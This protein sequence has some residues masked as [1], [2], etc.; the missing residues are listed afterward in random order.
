[1]NEFQKIWNDVQNR[2]FIEAYLVLFASLLILVVDLFGIETETY[3]SEVTLAALSILI[4]LNIKERREYIKLISHEGIKGISAFFT[5]R[6]GL[7][8]LGDVLHNA[9]KEIILYSVKHTTLV[10]QYLHLLE[11]KAAS[12]CEVKI[13]LMRARDETGIINPNVLAVQEQTPQSNALARLEANTTILR[14]WYNCLSEK[15]KRRVRIKTYWEHPRLSYTFVDRN[16]YYGYVLV[17]IMLP[18][19]HIDS[20]PHYIVTNKD[21]GSLYKTHCVSFD[22]LWKESLDFVQNH[23]KETD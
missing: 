8:N 11:E 6:E 12:G 17:G 1:M 18:E 9:K 23:P 4:Y 7:P 20:L 3:L 19:V 14:E 15:V 13:L 21:G 10:H 16:E 5:K 2:Q 22:G